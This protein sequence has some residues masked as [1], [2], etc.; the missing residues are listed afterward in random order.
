[1]PEGRIDCDPTY[2]TGSFYKGTGIEPP[3]LRFDIKPQAEGVVEADARNLPLE[4][5]FISCL[6]LDPPFL[7][8]TGKSL[9]AEKRWHPDLQ[10]PRQG[11]Q[12]KA[13]LHACVCDGYS[14]GDG[15]LSERSVRA[16]GKKPF[17]G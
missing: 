16:A 14:G 9:L 11:Q 5:G 13:V 3:N 4:E 7:A 17:N 2:S 8:T 15:I 12:R 6:V 10:V 1:M